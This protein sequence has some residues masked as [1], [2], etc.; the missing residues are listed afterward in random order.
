[1]TIDQ[2]TSVTIPPKFRFAVE[3]FQQY[4]KSE[5][6]VRSPRWRHAKLHILRIAE[7]VSSITTS[8]DEPV[9]DLMR[10]AS[11]LNVLLEPIKG[12]NAD[13]LPH[14]QLVPSENGFRMRLY[15][16]GWPEISMKERFTIAHELGHIFFYSMFSDR[17]QRIIPPSFGLAPHESQRE[18]GLCD[19]FASALLV[20]NYWASSIAA[21][22]LKMSEI[23]SSSEQLQVSPEVLIRR[24]IY[25]L[26][27]WQE[28][29][30]YSIWLKGDD[31][32]IVRIFR[33]ASRKET[34]SA[35]AG[36]AVSRLMNGLSLV[37]AI[38]KLNEE[39]SFQSADI[40]VRS[41][42]FFYVKI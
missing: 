3:D 10:V 36:T 28:S 23:I 39:K 18:E 22:R 25:D 24:V 15:S 21:R 27:G 41:T 1:M 11:L 33:G 42:S 4:I 26:A 38:D 2:S 13:K 37:E 32:T 14:G 34:T 35:P 9:I 20:P 19:S 7:E 31:E 40:F 12:K 30:I 5:Y 29:A 17:S 8:A 16:P 6:N